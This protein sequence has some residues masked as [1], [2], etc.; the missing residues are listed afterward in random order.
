MDGHM[1]HR[2]NWYRKIGFQEQQFRTQFR[3]QGLPDCLGAF[4]GT[5]DAAVAEWIGNRLEQK[6]AGPN[7]VY[8]VTLNSHLPVPVPSPLRNAASCSL[9][10]LLLQQPALCSW[11]QLVANVHDS[12]SRLALVDLA[13]PTVFVIVGDHAPP[14]ADPELRAQFSSTE[15]PFVILVPRLDKQPPSRLR[16]CKAR[17]S[18]GGPPSLARLR[19]P[20]VESMQ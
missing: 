8:W 12:V 18:A 3:R 9:T 16:S 13:R 4:S 6:D 17:P 7:F 19:P 1:Y 20:A 11:Y 5:C 10:P 2:L 15:V 14:F